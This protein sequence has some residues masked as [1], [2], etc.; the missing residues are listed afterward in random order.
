[1]SGWSTAMPGIPACILWLWLWLVPKTFL[2][3]DFENRCTYEVGFSGQFDTLFLDLRTNKGSKDPLQPLLPFC[4]PQPSVLMFD[5]VQLILLTL[6]ST[7]LA[8]SLTKLISSIRQF[9][10]KPSFWPCSTFP[11]SKDPAA[12][13]KVFHPGRLFFKNLKFNN[14]LSLKL[15]SSNKSAEL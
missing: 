13:Q 10:P 3:T 7:R 1:M 5:L 12:V 4:Q 11:L 6:S 8:S 14:C 2:I 9:H 15:R